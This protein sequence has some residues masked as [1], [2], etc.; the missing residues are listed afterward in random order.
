M[1]GPQ[2]PPGTIIIQQQQ[3]QGTGGSPWP[4]VFGLALP[5]VAFMFFA[6]GFAA[7]DTPDPDKGLAGTMY[8]A[9]VIVGIVAVVAPMLRR[10][11]R[12]TFAGAL[13]FAVLFGWFMADMFDG[14]YGDGGFGFTLAHLLF[15]GPGILVAYGIGALVGGLMHR[16]AGV[17]WAF[18]MVGTGVTAGYGVAAMYHL[19]TLERQVEEARAAYDTPGIG[20][21]VLAVA[22]LVLAW[23]RRA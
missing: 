23:R 8:G 22:L 20:I 21:V 16:G 15:I 6:M 10:E 7:V 9:T 3:Q 1:D 12:L 4:W 11:H 13:P 18:Q 19:A 2:H 17:A 5:F 14:A